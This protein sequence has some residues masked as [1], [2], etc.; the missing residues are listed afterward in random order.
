M[1]GPSPTRQDRRGTSVRKLLTTYLIIASARRS[2]TEKQ[3]SMKDVRTCGGTPMTVRHLHV[4]GDATRREYAAYVAVATH[5]QTGARRFYVGKTGDNRVGCNPLIS[6]AGNHFSYNDV[7]SQ[8]RNYLPGDPEDYDYDYFYTGFGPYADPEQSR[9]GIDIINEM[10]RQLNLMAQRAF[11]EI[12]NPYRGR[13]RL[14]RVQQA[15]RGELFTEERRLKLAQ[16][17]EAAQGFLTRG[18]TSVLVEEEAQ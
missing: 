14:T 4:P 6:R 2:E 12:L 15:A 3:V 1:S 11:G 16:V 9:Q 10:E 13:G 5:R 18:A 17:I 7:H 8:M